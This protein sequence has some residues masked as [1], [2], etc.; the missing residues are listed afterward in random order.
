MITFIYPICQSCGLD[1][2]MYK[3]IGDENGN[4]NGNGNSNSGAGEISIRGGGEGGYINQ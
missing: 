1:N 3:Y 2:H 4:N